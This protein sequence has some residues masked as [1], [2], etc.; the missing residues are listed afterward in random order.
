ML[1]LPRGRS[2]CRVF[3]YAGKEFLIDTRARDMGASSQLERIVGEAELKTTENGL[4]VG[5]FAPER[6]MRLRL[7]F[8]VVTLRRLWSEEAFGNGR[9]ATTEALDAR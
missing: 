7:R 5:D 1:F 6:R 2:R 8:S 3:V 9:K 4:D